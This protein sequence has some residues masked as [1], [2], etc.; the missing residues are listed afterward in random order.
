MQRQIH[1]EAEEDGSARAASSRSDASSRV[2][3]TRSAVRPITVATPQA[4][5]KSVAA[6]PCSLLHSA[7]AKTRQGDAMRRLFMS[8]Q[9]G[10][11]INPE[12]MTVSAYVEHVQHPE[13]GNP[14]AC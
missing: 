12:D 4:P 9:K 2:S 7:Y 1:R 10:I 6:A 11:A 8:S 3:R 13:P 5:D 14:G